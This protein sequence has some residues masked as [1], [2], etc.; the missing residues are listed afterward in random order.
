MP[1]HDLKRWVFEAFLEVTCSSSTAPLS[2]RECGRWCTP[3]EADNAT[4]KEGTGRADHPHAARGWAG[5]WEDCC[6]AGKSCSGLGTQQDEILSPR[7]DEDR[8]PWNVAAR[9]QRADSGMEPSRTVSKSGRH[10]SNVRPLRPERSAL[11]R[12]SY[13]PMGAT[14]CSSHMGEIGR[15]PVRPTQDNAD[16]RQAMKTEWT[17]GFLGKN[18]SGRG[19]PPARAGPG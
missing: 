2:G 4:R 18:G 8:R 7:G 3:R 6:R 9:F 13:A 11:A 19:R 16:A 5:L 1:G 17:G 15:L 10:D 12:L 14:N